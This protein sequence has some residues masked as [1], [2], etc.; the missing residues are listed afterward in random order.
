[1]LAPEIRPTRDLPRNLWCWILGCVMTYS[2]LF[3][4]GKLLLRHSE[5]GT[6]L[7][8]LALACAWLMWRE[9]DRVKD[10]ET[11]TA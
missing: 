9:L 10:T 1:M 4:V 3:G 6:F 7:V 5:L 11:D 2:A 8:L